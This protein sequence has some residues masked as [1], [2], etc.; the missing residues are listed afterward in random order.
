MTTCTQSIEFCECRLA[1]IIINTRLFPTKYKG[2]NQKKKFINRCAKER[3]KC[4][5][6]VMSVLVNKNSTVTL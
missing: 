5:C 2:S 6:K 4:S 1:Y 3:G